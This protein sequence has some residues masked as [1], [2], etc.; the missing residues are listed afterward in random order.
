[1]TASPTRHGWPDADPVRLRS[2]ASGLQPE[3]KPTPPDGGPP[4]PRLAETLHPPRRT[5]TLLD[6]E[7]VLDATSACLDEFGYDGT[8]IRRIAQELGCAVGSIYRYARDKRELLA[9][10]GERRF[11]PVLTT[12]EAHGVAASARHYLELAQARP[13][14][15]RLMYWLAGIGI[16]TNPPARPAAEGTTPPASPLPAVVQRIC[17]GWSQRLGHDESLQLWSDVHGRALLGLAEPPAIATD[18]AV[19][20]L[21]PAEAGPGTT[22]RLAG[23]V[24]ENS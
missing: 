11:E 22:L 12:L 18:Q 4:S 16:N 2:T 15:Y 24:T 13:E 7:S 19:S 20:D 23:D 21:H 6:R 3:P 8:T 9:A 17:D 1:M 10:V 5:P 14:G